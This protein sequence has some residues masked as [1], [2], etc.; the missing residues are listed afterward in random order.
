MDSADGATLSGSDSLAGSPRVPD[1][2]PD[3]TQLPCFDGLAERHDWGVYGSQDNLGTLNNLTPQRVAAA[4][5]EIRTGQRISLQ[6]PP[7]L[8]DPPLYD[9]SAP[10]HEITQ[11]A[12]NAWDDRVD[13]FY[14]QWST[15][16]DGLRHMRFR[17]FGFYG[18]VTQTPEQMGDRL[19][20]HHWATQGIIGR[21]VLLDVARH[22]DLL[23]EHI[24]AFSERAVTAAELI[25]VAEQQDVEIQPGDVLCIRTGWASAYK[26]IEP[27]QRP[28]ISRGGTPPSFVGLSAEQA[29]AQL[30]WDW[31]VSAIAADNPAV[32]VSPGSPASGSLH[33]RCL[34]QL[35][36]PLGELFDLDALAEVSARDGRWSF[37]CVSVPLA[38]LGGVGTPANVIAIR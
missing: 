8:P 5:A 25:A 35:G 32:E 23:G 33:R 38:I 3:F 13:N 6:L 7:H 29:T 31:H 37:F 20:V 11:T 10:S 2:L 21:G 18:G 14:P 36:I 4:A 30:L 26:A 22:F 19:G 1:N 16:W 12:R 15:Q 24:D 34:V 27:A 28:T 9:R 17:E